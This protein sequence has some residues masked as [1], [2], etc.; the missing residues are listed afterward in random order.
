MHQKQSSVS[1]QQGTPVTELCKSCSAGL[2]R[3]CAWQVEENYQNA[4]EHTPELFS[5]VTMLYVDME[6]RLETR[7]PAE[8]PGNAG[9]HAGWVRPACVTAPGPGG[10]SLSC[11]RN[12]QQ[13]PASFAA[14]EL[15]HALQE[16]LGATGPTGSSIHLCRN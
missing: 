9:T 8:A 5:S 1:L 15:C 3:T 12:S 7:A 13:H 4:Y 14:E 11:P 2:R 10:A 16:S 6:V